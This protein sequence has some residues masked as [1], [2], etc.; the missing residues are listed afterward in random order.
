MKSGWK[1]P[2]VLAVC[3]LLAAAG[4]VG[5]TEPAGAQP[6][7]GF[8]TLLDAKRIGDW[9]QTGE[10]NW[11]LEDGAV[12]ADKGKGGHLV[13]K[14]VYKDF[15]IRAEFWVTPEGNSGIFIRC[16]DPKAIGAKTCYE[17]NI[18]DTRPDPSYGTGAIVN[19]AE[20]KPM[21]KVA[22][23]WATMEIT[24]KG[25]RIT[26]KINGRQTV[27]LQN[28]LFEQGHFTVQYGGGVVKFRKVEIK[29]L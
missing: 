12:V 18:W 2:L 23:K 9:N 8:T 21:R 15:V 1:R 24:A 25:R 10:A 27:D 3:S 7:G 14:Q 26:V 29:A 22:G 17:V 28:G 5:M 16:A 13:S 20:V 11:R 6:A 4:I 19:F